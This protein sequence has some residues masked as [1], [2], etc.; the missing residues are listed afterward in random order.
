MR[1]GIA[2]L[3]AADQALAREQKYCAVLSSKR[4]GV[5][6]KPVK[7]MLADKPVFVCCEGC[8]DQ[9]K[10]DQEKTL[11]K[12]EALKTKAKGESHAHP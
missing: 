1:A 8:Q 9:A 2:E 11:A 10:E 7:L 12:V 6:G 5:M 3:P 4:L